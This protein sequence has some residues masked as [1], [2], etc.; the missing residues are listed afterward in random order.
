VDR[1]GHEVGAIVAAVGRSDGALGS[2]ACAILTVREDARVPRDRATGVVAS[3]AVFV[4]TAQVPAKV[5][6]AAILDPYRAARA[7]ADSAAAL[8]GNEAA[9]ANL[10][11]RSTVV[12]IRLEIDTDTAAVGF[13]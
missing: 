2:D 1:A 12:E 9:L 4:V 5:D 6:S 13:T 7:L 8:D 10:A 11:A 3:A